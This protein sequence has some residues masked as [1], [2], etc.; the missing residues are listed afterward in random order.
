MK[1]L[2]F[3]TRYINKEKQIAKRFQIKVLVNLTFTSLNLGRT[4]YSSRSR[5]TG[6]KTFN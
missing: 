4:S 5:L 1:S 6:L 2:F 3:K